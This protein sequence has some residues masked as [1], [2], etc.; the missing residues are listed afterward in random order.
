MIFFSDREVKKTHQVTY[1]KVRTRQKIDNHRSPPHPNESPGE[2]MQQ[3]QNS[4]F[5]S[6][7]ER[8]KKSGHFGRILMSLS[9][10]I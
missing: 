7:K 4:T 6:N 1:P 2:V 3:I 8:K 9:P 10:K 5:H